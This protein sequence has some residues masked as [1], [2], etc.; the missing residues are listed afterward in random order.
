MPAPLPLLVRVASI[1]ISASGKGTQRNKVPPAFPHRKSAAGK[2]VSSDTQSHG[3]AYTQRLSFALPQW[4]HFIFQK[5]TVPLSIPYPSLS[6]LEMY[7]VV[8]PP[9][10]TVYIERVSMGIK[11]RQI[12]I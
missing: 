12:Q 8:M 11:I 6:C 1:L 7:P 2:L 10:P 3:C 9:M 5:S 4:Y